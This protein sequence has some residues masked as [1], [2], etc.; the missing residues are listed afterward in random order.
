[1]SN[2]PEDVILYNGEPTLT[3]TYMKEGYYKWATKKSGIMKHSSLDEVVN[4]MRR[5]GYAFKIVDAKASED[6]DSF[7]L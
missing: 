3:V 1:M 2:T 7:T 5:H 6:E 4:Y